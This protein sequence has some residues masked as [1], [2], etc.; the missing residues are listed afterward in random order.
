MSSRVVGSLVV[1]S[2]LGLYWLG[3]REFY[4]FQDDLISLAMVVRNW[5]R[6]LWSPNAEHL[7]TLTFSLFRLEWSLWGMS[8]A[9]F[10]AVS[11][12][13]FGAL[14]WSIYLIILRET[15]SRWLAT[16]TVGLIV[17]N[18]NWGE[19]I[20]W[21]TGQAILLATLFSVWSFGWILHLERK[22]V[23]WWW[24]R[25]VLLASLVLPSLCWGS[26]LV[27]PVAVFLG[28]GIWRVGGKIRLKYPEMLI[29]IGVVIGLYYAVAHDNMGIHFGVASW[30]HS[31][32][33]IGLFVAIAVFENMLGR[34]VWPFEGLVVR[35]LL[36]AAAGLGIVLSGWSKRFRWSREVVFCAE[37]IAVTMIGFAIPRWQFGMG[38][39]MAERYG[40]LPLI[41]L[42]MGMALALKH[43]QWKK[44]ER[45]IVT[46]MVVY[47]ILV[48]WTGFV[49]KA[50][51][52]KVRP[53]QT[54]V[55][56]S[57][58]AK[59]EKEECLAN[60]YLPEFVIG[61]KSEKWKIDYIWPILKK[62]FDPF[63]ESEAGRER[64]RR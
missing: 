31:P 40:F 30:L 41:F 21:V 44:Q 38:Q 52:W 10:L 61:I 48:G 58:L 13:L 6:V 3:V 28:W 42:V 49:Q 45:L 24:E 19:M 29:A 37:V 8:Y 35:N 1:L 22:K 4:F 34:W 14:L 57:D 33:Q 15:S 53:Q 7:N 55:W 20:W 25:A 23:T 18:R 64:C 16:M 59:T 62:D 51:S 12:G 17:I 56:L 5:P 27:W 60:E 46:A 63:A 36:V 2:L 39:A 9:G 54:K 26:G 47:T 32:W 43:Y 11:L 50:Q